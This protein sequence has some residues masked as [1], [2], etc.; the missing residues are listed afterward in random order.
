MADVFFFFFFGFPSVKCVERNSW[1][2]SSE[3]FHKHHLGVSVNHSSSSQRGCSADQMNSIRLVEWILL[4]ERN[5]PRQAE[6]W[7]AEQPQNGFLS[8]L[9]IIL[10]S[11]FPIWIWSPL[12]IWFAT[13][14]IKSLRSTNGTPD[15]TI[16]PP[17]QTI[18]IP[19]EQNL[20]HDS[21][22]KGYSVLLSSIA[23]NK[24]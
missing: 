24:L 2:A 6:I 21:G 20:E 22:V 11:Q 5:K 8:D 14:S 16:F 3:V 18:P 12:P 9:V 19:R 7:S 4:W 17:S 23:T 1:P 15:S 10:R 13:A